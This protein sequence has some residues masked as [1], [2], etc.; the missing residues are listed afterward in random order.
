M[1]RLA[2]V[3]GASRGIGRAIA[4]Q[5]AKDGWVPLIHYR[6]RKADAEEVASKSGGI[7]APFGADL[8]SGDV[9]KRLWDWA[10]SVGEISALV[11][12]AGVYKP[13]AF[14]VQSDGEFEETWRLHYES[15]F[16]STLRLTRYFVKSAARGA[17]ILNVC[18]RVGYRG[19]AGAAAYAASKAAQINLTRSLAVELAAKGI[20][21]FGIAPGWVE[22]AMT[23]PGMETRRAEIEAGIPLGRVASPE[24]CAAAAAFLLSD[25]AMYLSGVVLDVNGAS[26]F[27]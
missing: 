18:S 12:N 13:M 27:H 21:V 26:Y 1:S 24:D 25:E 11:N 7:A 17:R 10:V 15:N 5:L 19:E 16:L 9:C 2:L 20:G 22:T 6:E 4:L 3:T 14:D 23:R 8:S